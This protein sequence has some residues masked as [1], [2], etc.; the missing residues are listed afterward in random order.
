MESYDTLILSGNSTNALVTLGALQYLIDKG[1]IGEV[2]NYVGTSSG[3]ILSVLL[4]IG[5]QPIE[6]LTHLCVEK[7]YKKMVQFNISNMLLMGKPLMNFEPIKNS[8]EQLIIDK[9]GHMPSMKSVESSGR[10]LFFATYNLT[11]DCRE[12]ISSDTYP[13]LPVINGIHMSSNFPFVFDPYVFENKAYLDGG[14]VDNFAVEFGQKIGENCLGVM[15]INPRRKYDPHDFG[16][17]E[18]M[19]LLFQTFIETVT[20][21]KIERTKCDIIKLDCASNF[22]NFNSNNKELINMFD[23]GYDLCRKKC[24]S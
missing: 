16:T 14:I 10:R 5:Y 22:F 7:I 18:F 8:L 6:I 20:S 15:T 3:A 12:Y 1:R 11:D 9:I 13:D 17:L 19:W 4:V 24:N 2:K 23:K 21:D